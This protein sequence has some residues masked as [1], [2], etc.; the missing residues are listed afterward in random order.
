MKWV[1]MEVLASAERSP[2]FQ[3]KALLTP[4]SIPLARCHVLLEGSLPPELHSFEAE[5]DLLGSPVGSP[6]GRI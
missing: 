6:M 3:S 1:E 2:A 5:Q 4:Q